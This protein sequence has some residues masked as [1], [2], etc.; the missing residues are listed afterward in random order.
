MAEL[1]VNLDPQ[2]VDDIVRREIENG[3]VAAIETGE[4]GRITRE[5]IKTVLDM[6]VD[7]DG[8]VTTYRDGLTLTQYYFSKYVREKIDDM[9]KRWASDNADA[10]AEEF[11]RQLKTAKG[12]KGFVASL[13][14]GIAGVMADNYRLTINVK[15]GE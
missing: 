5:V 11:L 15:L 8:K 1:K 2:T 6:R 7:R 13:M 3:L 9:I 10:I 4:P 14:A 12:T